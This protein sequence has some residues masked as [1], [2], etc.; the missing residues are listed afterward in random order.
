MTTLFTLRAK[1]MRR[2]FV[3]FGAALGLVLYML[4][5]IPGWAADPLWTALFVGLLC[6]GLALVLSWEAENRVPVEV[7]PAALVFAG[8]VFWAWGQIIEIDHVRAHGD[9]LRQ[10][11]VIVAIVAA[12][13]VLLPFLQYRYQHGTLST[14]Y[15]E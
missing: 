10:F 2:F 14:P 9:E 7:L 8:L 15:A 4:T 13:Y 11:T 5:E 12:G 6:A 3:I 1:T